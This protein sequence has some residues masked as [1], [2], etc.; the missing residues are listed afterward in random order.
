MSSPFSS[1]HAFK[2]IMDEL[3]AML[4]GRHPHPVG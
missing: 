3:S 4:E 2:Q 1:L